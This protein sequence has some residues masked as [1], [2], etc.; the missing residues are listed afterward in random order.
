MVAFDGA[1][2]SRGRWAESTSVKESGKVLLCVDIADRTIGG[3]ARGVGAS[4]G[5]LGF[6]RLGSKGDGPKAVGVIACAHD[7][8]FAVF[9]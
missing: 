5:C 4:R 6:G 7:D 3:V 2:K 9:V 1:K 8:E